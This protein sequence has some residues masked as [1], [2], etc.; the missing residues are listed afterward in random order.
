MEDNKIILQGKVS[1][2]GK[3][4]V[5][6]EHSVVHGKAAILF[7]INKRIHL[8]YILSLISSSDGDQNSCL[9]TINDT[10]ESKFILNQFKLNFQNK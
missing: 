8:E 5:S 4:I 10:D 3:I 6:G 7:A 9:I 1:A 2:P